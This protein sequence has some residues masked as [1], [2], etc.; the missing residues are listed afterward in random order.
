MIRLDG[1]PTLQARE[2]VNLAT[3][4]PAPEAQASD[5]SAH[6]ASSAGPG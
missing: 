4:E 5:E 6:R 1:W 2:R 3:I